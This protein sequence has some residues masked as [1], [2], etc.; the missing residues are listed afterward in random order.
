[1]NQR[2]LLPSQSEMANVQQKQECVLR[3]IDGA[4]RTLPGHGLRLARRTTRGD[5]KA[6]LLQDNNV[7]AAWDVIRAALVTRFISSDVE[8]DAFSK[9]SNLSQYADETV[10]TFWRRTQTLI[11]DAFTGDL[12]NDETRITVWPALRRE[13]NNEGTPEALVTANLQTWVAL[14]LK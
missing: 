9:L 11:Q 8:A 7:G 10:R 12:N 4:I 5:L 2:Q 14:L 3:E 1:M 13:V 6:F